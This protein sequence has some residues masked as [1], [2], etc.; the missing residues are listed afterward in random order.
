MPADDIEQA[1][2]GRVRRLNAGVHALVVGLIFGI[3]LFVATLWLVI[4]GG[5]PVGPH[6]ALLGYYFPGYRVT[7]TGAFIGLGYGLVAGLVVG[8]ATA[9]I[10]NVLTGL[11]RRV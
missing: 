7:W 4:Q 1:L 11:R 3:G 10:Y 2:A 8:Y 6:L 9:R 5:Q